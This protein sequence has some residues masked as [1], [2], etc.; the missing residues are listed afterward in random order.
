MFED[1]I[2]VLDVGLGEVVIK[3]GGTTPSITSLLI[4]E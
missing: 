2:G 4:R 1:A 3:E